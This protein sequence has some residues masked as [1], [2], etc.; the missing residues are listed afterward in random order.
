MLGRRDVC[1]VPDGVRKALTTVTPTEHMSPPRHPCL[2]VQG[3]VGV[4][5]SLVK[6]FGRWGEDRN[7]RWEI[8]LGCDPGGLV[9][10]A[11]WREAEGDKLGRAWRW[12]PPLV[13]EEPPDL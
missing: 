7:L 4:S 1:V 3:P 11:G 8:V 2:P 10:G 12:A 6:G 5:P 13:S 9:R